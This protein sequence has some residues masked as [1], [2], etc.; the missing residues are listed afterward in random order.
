ME[1]VCGVQPVAAMVSIEA[2][3]FF[4]GFSMGAV[5]PSHCNMSRIHDDGLK[6]RRR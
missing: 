4:S 5:M 1:A 2:K 3:L 6:V